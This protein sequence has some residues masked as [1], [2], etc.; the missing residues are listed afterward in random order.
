MRVLRF[1]L[2]LQAV[3]ALLQGQVNETVFRRA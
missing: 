3:D 2:D 1:A